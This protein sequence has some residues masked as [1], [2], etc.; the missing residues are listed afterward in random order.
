[1]KKGIALTA[2]CMV[3]VLVFSTSAQAYDYFFSYDAAAVKAAGGLSGSVGFAYVNSSKGWDA[4]GDSYTYADD[5]TFMHIP[6]RVN[7]GLTDKVTIFG[8]VTAFDKWDRGDFGESGFGDTWL[9]AKCAVL[10]ALTLRGA[11]DI[12]TGDGKKDLGYMGGFGIDVAAMSSRQIGEL[13]LNGQV[14]SRWNA[15]DGNTKFQPGV[16][17]YIDVEG[18][19]SFTEA[20]EGKAGFEYSVVG[21]GKSSGT[22]AKDSGYA[23]LDL[24][25]GG[26]Y[27][28]NEKLSLGTNLYYTVTGTSA[29]QGLT[30]LVNLGYTA[31]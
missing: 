1:M 23:Y 17:G 21:D 18:V 25:G 7:Y 8:L 2:L 15:E 30:L 3:G 5:L 9:G 16:G 11:L 4:G 24:R 27:R 29:Y 10:P 19:Y 12:P 22:D 14:G 6:L 31:K 28:L 20:L 26:A 13:G